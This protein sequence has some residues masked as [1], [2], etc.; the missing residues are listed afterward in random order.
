MGVM[1]EIIR[2]LV[3]LQDTLGAIAEAEQF[4]RKAPEQIEALDL[5]LE[6]AASGLNVVREELAESQ[7]QRRALEMDIASV[8]TQINRHQE[9]TMSVKTNEAYR[10]L[11]HEIEAERAKVSKLEDRVLELMEHSDQLEARIKVLES[12]HVQARGRTEEEKRGVM[13]KGRAAS[14]E[15]ERLQEVRKG[16]ELKIPADTLENFNR[17][18]SARGG[19]GIVV[20]K[21]ELCGGCNVRLRPQIFQEVRRAEA[22]HSCESCKRYLYCPEEPCPGDAAVESSGPEAGRAP[23]GG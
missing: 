7:K 4:E 8:E 11:Q 21:N 14:K 18:A 9:Q 2:S 19:V 13:E 12:E 22:L 15:L 20:A 6:E 23:A 1:K 17:I 10:T 3:K 5:R 16:I